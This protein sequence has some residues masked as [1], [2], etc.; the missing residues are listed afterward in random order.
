MADERT[1]PPSSQG[2]TSL[3][4]LFGLGGSWF[5]SVRE[6]QLRPE[7]ATWVRKAW[8]HH[9]V[10]SPGPRQ[11]HNR[12]TSLGSVCYCTRAAGAGM[13]CSIVSAM[14]YGRLGTTMGSRHSSGADLLLSHHVLTSEL[15]LAFL[16][17]RCPPGTA[18]AVSGRRPRTLK[19]HESAQPDSSSGGRRSWTAAAVGVGEVPSSQAPRA[20]A[21]CSRVD[22]HRKQAD[23]TRHMAGTPL[24]WNGRR[25]EGGCHSG[26]LRIV[27][28]RPPAPSH[29]DWQAGRGTCTGIIRVQHT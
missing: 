9:F 21:S 13:G 10:C 5:F 26:A 11:A 15:P 17:T 25:V 14:H 18:V 6:S 20:R 19:G 16:A 27:G 2:S 23:V 4:G 8:R 24:R 7:P 3:S 29:R 12:K 1:D 22:N 28:I